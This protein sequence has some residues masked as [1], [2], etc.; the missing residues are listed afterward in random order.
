MTEA[1]DATDSFEDVPF[2]FRHH[3]PKVRHEFPK[4][5]ILT[6]ERKKYLADKRAQA[7]RIED[8]KKGNGEL[9]DGQVIVETSL[10]FVSEAEPVL[11][12]TPRRK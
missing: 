2:D 3:S 4:E 10:P 9:V 11:I 8:Q 5:W 12:E 7:A 1:K 6:P